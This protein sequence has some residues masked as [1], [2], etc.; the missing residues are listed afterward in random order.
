MNFR[1]IYEIDLYRNYGNEM[2]LNGNKRNILE[3]LL[4]E[5]SVNLQKYFQ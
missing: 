1:K 2:L 5:N 3:V 4:P